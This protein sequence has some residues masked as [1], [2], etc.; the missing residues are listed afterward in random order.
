[1]HL[2]LFCMQ[3]STWMCF[4][5]ISFIWMHLT[6]FCKHLHALESVLIGIILIWVHMILFCMHLSLYYLDFFQ[7]ECTWLGLVC[8]CMH[9][10]LLWLHFNALLSTSRMWTV[11]IKGSLKS[12]VW[13]C[14]H[15]KNLSWNTSLQSVLCPIP[16]AKDW[17]NSLRCSWYS[18][19]FVK[20][21]FTLYWIWFVIALN[22]DVL[23]LKTDAIVLIRVF[24]CLNKD[25][26]EFA[27]WHP[28]HTKPVC[29]QSV[30][31][32][33]IS[34]LCVSSSEHVCND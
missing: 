28:T 30:C 25:R 33:T 17:L 13:I 10:N 8:T 16:Y 27:I 1:M 34:A 18:T 11:C 9:L 3:L 5:W 26:K 22:R 15:L 19:E 21:Q 7:C 31:I 32:H 29:N 23:V 24:P 14:M 2:N 6:S 20:I 4:V 12:N